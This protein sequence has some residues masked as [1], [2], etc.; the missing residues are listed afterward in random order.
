[1]NSVDEAEDRSPC[2]DSGTSSSSHTCVV[3][4]VSD[5]DNVIDTDK[6]SS[7]DGGYGWVWV[8]CSFVVHFF[9]LGCIPQAFTD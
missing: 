3:S 5:Q 4:G 6:D 8:F 1:M 7:P 9:A 2:A